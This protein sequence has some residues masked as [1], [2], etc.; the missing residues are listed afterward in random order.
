M[1]TLAVVVL[2]FV[3][4]FAV[5]GVMAWFLVQINPDRPSVS[6][7]DMAATIASLAVGGVLI[8]GPVVCA[9]RR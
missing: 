5:A 7:G 3:W 8:F 1:K 9:A 6:V 4:A 2:W